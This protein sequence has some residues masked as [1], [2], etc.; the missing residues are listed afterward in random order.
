MADLMNC[1]L[2]GRNQSQF[3]NGR[4]QPKVLHISCRMYAYFEKAD[5]AAGVG[6]SEMFI[7]VK[8]YITQEP[9]VSKF[10]PGAVKPLIATQMPSCSENSGTEFKGEKKKKH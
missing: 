2:I 10:L 1:H 6:T 9:G 5:A 4:V 8:V 3:W 7:I